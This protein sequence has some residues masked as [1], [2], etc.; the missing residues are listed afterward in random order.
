MTDD[1]QRELRRQLAAVAD[2]LESLE[3]LRDELAIELA[4]RRDLRA[5]LLDHEARITRLEATHRG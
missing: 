3:R 2:T 1:L 4:H 5:G